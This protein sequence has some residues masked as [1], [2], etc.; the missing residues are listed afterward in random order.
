MDVVLPSVIRRSRRPLPALALTVT[1]PL[2]I[3]CAAEPGGAGTVPD[4]LRLDEL[5][6][7]AELR[8]EQPARP[9]PLVAFEFDDGDAT[10][11]TAGSQSST[12]SVSDGVLRFETEGPDRLMGPD[13]LGLR[14]EE[15]DIVSLRLRASG[16]EW[17]DLV[18]RDDN[19]DDPRSRI[20]MRTGPDPNRAVMVPANVGRV[21]VPIYEQD[22]WLTHDVEMM[23]FG[24]WRRGIGPV[25]ERPPDRRLLQLG[26]STPTASVVE[27]DRLRV[28]RA[29]DYYFSGSEAGIAQYQIDRSLRSCLYTGG[30]GEITYEL[31]LPEDARFSCGL[32]IVEAEPP[33]VFSMEVE[34]AADVHTVFSRAVSTNT[35]WHDE[36]VDLS[37]FAGKKVALRLKT[38]TVAGPNVALWANPAIYRSG[39]RET[40]RLGGPGVNV[41]LYL[42]DCLRADHLAG[43]GYERDLAPVIESLAERGVSFDRFFTAD[44]WTKPSVATMESGVPSLVH[45]VMGPFGGVPGVLTTVQEMLRA[46]GIET[47]VVTENSHIGKLTNLARGFSFYEMAHLPDLEETFLPTDTLEL[48]EEFLR[49]HRDRPFFL[50]VHTIEAHAPYAPPPRYMES[51]LAP[52]ATPTDI[53]RYDGEVARADENLGR[54]LDVLSKFKLDRNTVLVILADHGEAFREHEGMVRHGGKPYNELLHVPLV[55]HVPGLIPE[56]RRRD[57]LAHMTDIAPTLLELFGIEP[58]PQHRGRSLLPLVV[59]GPADDGW[60]RALFAIGRGAAA[61]ISHRHKLVYNVT[62]PDRG[63]RHLYDL[64]SDMGETVDLAEDQPEIADALQRRILDDVAAQRKMGQEIR[65]LQGARAGAQRPVP[66]DPEEIARLRAMGYV[67]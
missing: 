46:H 7:A 23:G 41:V 24:V 32:G 10:G 59:G 9:E 43:F 2:L 33:V 42:I 48:A 4:V 27:I 26:L 29:S 8:I 17:I 56:G 28:M 57:E 15:A 61:A 60:E 37:K 11:W 25:H 36:K 31:I 66:L 34:T 38:T 30:P 62:G 20:P 22:R 45:G 1:L 58:A 19:E 52:G 35:S 18:W 12:V 3:A 44:T 40:P 47:A 16:T 39:Q 50:Y 49:A 55:F 13:D 64:S 65:R 5:L 21:Q 63:V 6:D 51:F 54:F 53:D 14:T 67:E